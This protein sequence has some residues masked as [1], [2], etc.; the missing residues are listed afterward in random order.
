MAILNMRK[1]WKEYLFV[2]IMLPITFLFGPIAALGMFYGVSEILQVIAGTHIW[3]TEIRYIDVWMCFTGLGGLSGLLGL[4]FY[5]IL[6]DQQI[7][8]TRSKVLVAICLL[9]GSGAALW[10]VFLNGAGYFISNLSVFS[11]TLIMLSIIGVY[12]AVD[13]LKPNE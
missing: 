10:V 8:R 9:A 11:I 7:K 3:N 1:R 5:I 2:L 6:R 4:W 12:S 13:V